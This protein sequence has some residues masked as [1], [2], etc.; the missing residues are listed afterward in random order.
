LEHLRCLG[1][2]GTPTAREAT[3]Q[4]PLT[5]V[6]YKKGVS[7]ATAS[8][9]PKNLKSPKISKKSLTN[10][11]V[12]VV[13]SRSLKPVKISYANG[14]VSVRI[15]YKNNIICFYL[16]AYFF[17]FNFDI[18]NFQCGERPTRGVEE[19]GQHPSVFA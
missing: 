7:G 3:E 16:L 12:S 13:I 2:P 1:C 15:F 6:C 19:D 5:V 8:H 17:V 4:A 18:Q 11:T 10:L 14:R 9:L